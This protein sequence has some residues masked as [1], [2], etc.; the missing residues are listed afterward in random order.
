[1]QLQQ[2]LRAAAAIV[3][4][5]NEQ[6]RYSKALMDA[7]RKLLV[8]G[9]VRISDYVIA[10]NNYLSAKNVITINA[11]KILFITNQLNYWK[12]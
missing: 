6:L 1:V 11:Q 7:N 2:Q 12:K 9:D 5:A 3:Q 8:Q 10:I 4:S